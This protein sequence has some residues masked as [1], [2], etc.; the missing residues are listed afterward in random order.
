[1]TH[2]NQ[3]N[4]NQT[5]FN[6]FNLVTYFQKIESKR[7]YNFDFRS[8]PSFSSPERYPELNKVYDKLEYL[9]Y[10]ENDSS[11]KNWLRYRICNFL[12][13]TQP[14]NCDN[15][16]E[17]IAI[18]QTLHWECE[19]TPQNRPAIDHIFSTQSFWTK[20]CTQHA[21]KCNDTYL[22][23]YL[24]TPSGK[25]L[26]HEYYLK[27]AKSYL[28]EFGCSL[29]N[30]NRLAQM[31][32]QLDAFEKYKESIGPELF[33]LLERYSALTFSLG[34]YMP[35]PSISYDLAKD[36]TLNCLNDR[37]DFFISY[38]KKF[39]S[40]KG[41]LRYVMKEK[42]YTVQEAEIFAW[43]DWFNTGFGD[44][45]DLPRMRRYYLDSFFEGGFLDWETSELKLL[46][47]T[48]TSLSSYLK[49][50]SDI[51]EDR[52]KKMALELK[53]TSNMLVF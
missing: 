19:T 27:R 46:P 15:C 31:L 20:A 17:I 40:G 3:T 36:S 18:F 33:G 8:L 34:N 24:T 52:G 12:S 29:T 28:E 23:R 13:P 6:Q 5:N 32:W 37:L 39:K 14:F 53:E 42:K 11:L 50:A 51:M 43:I 16:D 47:M 7:S 38:L 4:S 9:R 1:M 22:S 44:E 45:L 2:T 10:Q 49:I 21:S 30:A 35:C 48:G 25:I 41:S 26:L